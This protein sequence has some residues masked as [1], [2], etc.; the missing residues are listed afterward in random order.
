VLQPYRDLHEALVAAGA[1]DLPDLQVLPQGRA[2]AGI[3]GDDLLEWYAAAETYS[4]L[5]TRTEQLILSIAKASAW[6][7]HSCI[8]VRGSDLTPPWPRLTWPKLQAVRVFARDAAWSRT[9][10]RTDG[11]GDRTRLGASGRC[12]SRLPAACGSLAASSRGT[13]RSPSDSSSTSAGSSCATASV[14]LPTRR[15]T[16][17]L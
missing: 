2:A 15:A 16:A 11:D 6:G 10:R 1:S 8:K 4:D 3:C 12:S 13:H 9:L 5:M 7:E 14:N 17:A